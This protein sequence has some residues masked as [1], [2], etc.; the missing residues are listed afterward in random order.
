VIATE[1]D[2]DA[3]LQGIPLLKEIMNHFFANHTKSE[4]EFQQY[5]YIRKTWT[6]ESDRFNPNPFQHTVGLNR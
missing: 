4:R 2:C 5:E 1:T 6:K 3:W